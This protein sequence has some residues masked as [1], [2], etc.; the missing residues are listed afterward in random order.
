MR[1]A[2]AASLLATCLCL[3]GPAAAAPALWSVS[4]DDSQIFLFGSF[5]ILPPDADW[6]SLVF[7]Q[8][9]ADADTVVFETDIGPVAQAE[10]GAK[11]FARGMYV[12]GTLLS[13]VIGAPLDAKLRAEVATIG[14]PIGTLLAMR[15]WMAANAIS[16]AALMSEGYS[17]EGVEMALYPEIAAERMV[18]LET[19]D[20]Q[21][22]VL[23]GAPEA[24][25]IAM[26]E[27]TLAQ[28]DDLPKVMDKMVHNWL[29]G[30][31]DRLADLFLMEMGGF[32]AAF[33]DR[34]I[35]ARNQNWI[36]PLETM[37]AE[38]TEA[39][40]IV[41]A[42]HLIGDGSVIDLLGEAGYR[43]ERVE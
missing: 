5:H 9:L 10:I 2:C 41:G 12:D 13:D 39:M 24:E 17:L 27:A 20:E 37:L 29:N 7:E 34:L 32:E 23:A 28:M 8:A 16:V 4:D 11:A 19:G 14:M 33:M 25:Q 18:F 1:P 36:A 31:P 6:R 38:N 15:P 21:L 43:V 40:V 42:A 35:Y 30:T 26:L 3:A 22:D